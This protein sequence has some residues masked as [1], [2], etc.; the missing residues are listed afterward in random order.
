MELK[1]VAYR[2]TGIWLLQLWTVDLENA[3]SRL[4]EC[5]PCISSTPYPR[6]SQN[7][8]S[9]IFI[10]LTYSGQI[11]S[12]YLLN[13]GLIIDCYLH[14]FVDTIPQSLLLKSLCVESFSIESIVGTVLWH[15]CR[16]VFSVLATSAF[17]VNAEATV[18]SS[19]R[20]FANPADSPYLTCSVPFC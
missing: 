20:F 11:I 4:L 1:E 16:L 13:L 10:S 14:K 6:F 7:W 17:T 12:I 9:H 5:F 15:N 3:Y 2:P 18:L 8:T 19:S